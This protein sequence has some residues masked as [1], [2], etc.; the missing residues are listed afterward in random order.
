MINMMKGLRF[1][2]R[3]R[4]STHTESKVESCIFEF[5]DKHFEIQ[6]TE[7]WDVEPYLGCKLDKDAIKGLIHW[8]QGCLDEKK[9]DY[10]WNIEIPEGLDISGEIKCKKCGEFYR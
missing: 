10:C 7:K 3:N 5:R 1:C 2:E 6:N 8:L 9:C 4:K